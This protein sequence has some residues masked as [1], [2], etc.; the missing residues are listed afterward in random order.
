MFYFFHMGTSFPVLQQIP[1]D[2]YQEP[3]LCL[4]KGVIFH[5]E[6]VCKLRTGET[7]FN[8]FNMCKNSN[9]ILVPSLDEV[10]FLHCNNVFCV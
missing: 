9:N 4:S 3:E 5:A 1:M 8:A 6:F 10:L 2:Y 7:L